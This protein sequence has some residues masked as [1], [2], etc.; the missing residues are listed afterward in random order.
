MKNI[1][2]ALAVLTLICVWTAAFIAISCSN[3]S[4]GGD[5]GND[6]SSSEN[7]TSSRAKA[8]GKIGKYAAVEAIGDIVFSD[9]SVEAYSSGLTLSDTQKAAAVAVIFDVAGKKGVGF[10]LLSNVTL[11]QARDHYSSYGVSGFASGW[12]VPK[13]DELMTLYNVKSAVNG[14]L[15]KC[16]KQKMEA[17]GGYECDDAYAIYFTD[18]TSVAINYDFIGNACAIRVFN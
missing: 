10:D 8:T 6:S 17:S 9:G 2:K 15:E 18:G 4:S 3:N 5:T 16:G 12:Y 14:A 13:K 7:A 1:S 11:E